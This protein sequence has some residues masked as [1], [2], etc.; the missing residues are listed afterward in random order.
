MRDIKINVEVVGDEA[1]KGKLAAVDAVVDKIG[2][3]T[4]SAGRTVATFS[5]DTQKVL[6]AAAVG[7]QALDL[8]TKVN[9][10]VTDAG[11]I[12]DAMAATG[13]K[14]AESFQRIV[15]AAKLGGAE[16]PAVVASFTKMNDALGNGSKPTLAALDALGLTFAQLKQLAPDQQFIAIGNAVSQLQDPNKQIAL[17]NDLMGR[18][19]K[20]LLPAFK[21]GLEEVGAAAPVMSDAVVAA[22][23]K[24][25]D[26][27]DTLQEQMDTLRARALSPILEMFI[28]LPESVQI[29]VAGLREFLPSLTSLSLA[30]MA[31]GGPKAAFVALTG[32]I[33]TAGSTALGLITGAGAA[34]GTFLTTTL[35]AAF[36]ATVAF[37]GPQGLIALGLLALAGIW[38]IWGD[39][40]TA[41]VKRVYGAIKE[42]L[43]DKFAAVV[44]TVK[45]KV[46]AV[47]GF[48]RGMY[49]A[50]VGNSYVPDMVEGIRAEFGR[51][52][53]VMVAPAEGAISKVLSLFSD[54]K[55]GGGSILGNLLGGL[56]G[57]KGTGGS[58]LDGA[59]GG[60][61]TTG[62]TKAFNAAAPQI[63]NVLGMG[64]S[65]TLGA[66]L[67][68]IGAALGPLL[69]K[70]LG[71]AWNGIKSLFGGP[72]E[73]EQQG[74][75][76][77]AAFRSGI[78]DT[79]TDTQRLEAGNEAWKLSVIGVRDAYLAAGKT[80]QDALEAM[81]RLWK[82]EVR[83]AGAVQA[84]IETINRVIGTGTVGAVHA[85]ESAAV[86]AITVVTETAEERIA[87]LWSVALTGANPNYGTGAGDGSP[88]I[89]GSNNVR[90]IDFLAANINPKGSA[91]YNDIHR[92]KDVMNLNEFGENITDPGL[93]AE[94]QNKLDNEARNYIADNP[95]LF[96]GRALGGPVT[97]GRPY[98]VGEWGAEL[99]VPRTNGTIVPA[100]AGAGGLSI[101]IG[102]LTVDTSMTEAEFSRRSADALSQ[103]LRRRGVRFARA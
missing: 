73:A 44:D 42:W 10:Y 99:F 35:P 98:R 72:S 60:L 50:V 1:A 54:L 57:G 26:R 48:F 79:L 38:A 15:F 16:M 59:L 66:M 68:G 55:S 49:D 40:I 67:P 3:T 31:A 13:V 92:W 88:G 94:R 84:E 80:E 36:T 87:R 53:S 71:A 81:D 51:L 102:A 32:A 63:L 76:I 89:P 6:A 19:G 69:T 9:K 86:S 100:G 61:A 78:A 91:N 75:E 17:L 43:A 33:T 64:L 28:S 27:F 74:R 83:G 37:L 2:A 29:G 62:L 12:A 97:A 5:I 4:E 34:L 39:D 90:L 22:G 93:L 101:T 14:S 11:K 65:T 96:P 24:A 95:H 30:V 70:G 41:I 8:S 103:E 21:A 77:A 25:G 52:D 18:G 82:A 45:A 56:I 23:D 20:D 7:L 46:D 58:A 85:A 47:T